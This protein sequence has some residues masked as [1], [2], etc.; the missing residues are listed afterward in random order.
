[1]SHS[2]DQMWAEGAERSLAAGAHD[3]APMPA[4]VAGAAKGRAVRVGLGRRGPGPGA[5]SRQSSSRYAPAFVQ[6]GHATS[7]STHSGSESTPTE[8]TDQTESDD[9][10]VRALMLAVCMRA[11]TDWR[12]RMCAPQI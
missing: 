9:M 8:Q 12:R 6:H 7:E 5:D 4:E 1:M 10:L 2:P 11:C 3:D